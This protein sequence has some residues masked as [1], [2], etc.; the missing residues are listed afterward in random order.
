ML[1]PLDYVSLTGLYLPARTTD[2]I[3]SISLSD[4]WLVS[5]WED[6]YQAQWEGNEDTVLTAVSGQREY[7]EEWKSCKNLVIK[8]S[9]KLIFHLA[10]SFVICVRYK[11]SLEKTEL[12]FN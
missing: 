8:F 9:H 1:T 6:L 12:N 3:S 10:K 7:V 2:C 5:V 11:Y 4:V